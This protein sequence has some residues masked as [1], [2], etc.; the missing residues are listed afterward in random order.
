MRV[1]ILGATGGLGRAL[2]RAL[3]GH[4]LLL[5]GR[6]AEALRALGEEVGGKPLPADLTDELE[7]KALLEEAGPVDLL[8]HAVG[9]GARAPVR[10]TPRDL[11]E[12]TLQAHLL[13]AHLALKH[14]RFRP[15][16][17][18]AFFGAYPAYVRVPGFAAYAAAKGALEAYV[19]AARKE[20]RREGVHLVVVRLPA[21]ATGL[22]DPLGGP[23][24]HAL[25]P[26]EAA[27]K[28]LQG[29]LQEPPAE[30]LEV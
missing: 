4:E 3:K 28:V 7:A 25:S 24:R 26:E 21:V 8:L 20:F 6:R 16:A 29:L 10:E 18:A 27:A 19:E 23:P 1:L 12:E 22:W 9:V 13:T 30:L 17:R 2:A 15:G 11:L 5:S 14:A